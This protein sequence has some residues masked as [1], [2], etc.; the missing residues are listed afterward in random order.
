M[1]LK[2]ALNQLPPNIA[3]RALRQSDPS[4]IDR[5]TRDV[6]HAVYLFAR[7]D[8]T[9]EG[10]QYWL[11]VVTAL[12]ANETPPPYVKENYGNY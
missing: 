11:D 2:N 7:W 9:K 12:V 8:T 3:A 1:T 6:T 4:I 10:V 5:S